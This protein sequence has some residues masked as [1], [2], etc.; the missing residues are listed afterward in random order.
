M[1]PFAIAGMQLDLPGTENN[2]GQISARIDSML[3]LFPWVQ[4]VVLSELA[5]FGTSLRY[6]EPMPGPTEN[7]Y[8]QLA[9][10]HRVWLVPGSL[11]ERAS[12]KI[13][14]TAS[15]IDPTGRVVLRQRKLFPFRPYEEDVAAGTELGTFDIPGVGRFGVTVCYDMWFPETT[16]ALAAMGAEVILHPSLTTTIDRDIELSLARANAV[17]NQCYFVDVNG[18][19]GVGNGKSIVAGPFGEV[20][21]QAGTSNQVFPIELDLD[22]VR[23]TR[24]RGAHGLGQT[25]KSFRERE[26]DFACYREP[27]PFLASL[28]ALDKPTRRGNS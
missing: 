23:A 8:C 7:A 21:Y 9:A 22:L 19:G 11:Y 27:S 18:A 3:D 14:N 17:A 20:I 26:I 16:R 4:L 12:D 2:L 28:G 10:K 15:V 1:T 5:T 24:A 25:L 6:A 13:Y